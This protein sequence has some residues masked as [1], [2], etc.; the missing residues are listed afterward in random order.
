MSVTK[1]GAREVNGD[2]E[3]DAAACGL[4]RKISGP[5]ES[6]EISRAPSKVS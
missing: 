5:K 1:T 3:L 4:E 6:H 2:E